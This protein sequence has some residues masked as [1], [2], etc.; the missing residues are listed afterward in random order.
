M[1][2]FIDYCRYYKGEKTCPFPNDDVR[3][4]LWEY[5]RTWCEMQRKR[6][7]KMNDCLRD[8]NLYG[9]TVFEPYDGT[10]VSLKAFLFDRFAN[11]IGVHN[12]YDFKKWYTETYKK[13][14]Q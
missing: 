11:W 3:A 14:G 13:A 4:S 9:L 8:Y 5:E 10:P 7:A 12:A 2:A 6:D 1:P